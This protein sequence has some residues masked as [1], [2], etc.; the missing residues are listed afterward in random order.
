VHSDID[1]YIL[2]PRKTVSKV[3][4]FVIVA[5]AFLLILLVLGPCRRRSR[6][7]LVQYAVR[8]ACLLSFPLISYTL[9]LMQGH[10]ATKVQY[11]VWAS[12]LHVA[13]LFAGA[14]SVSVQKLDENRQWLKLFLENCMN[15]LY[16]GSIMGYLVFLPSHKGVPRHSLRSHDDHIWDTV[17][18]KR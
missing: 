5:A 17:Q 15:L 9:G 3:E 6:S 10:V 4:G 14:N 11:P 12:Y 13:P 8:G 1:Q 16:F 2:E 18:V 7:C